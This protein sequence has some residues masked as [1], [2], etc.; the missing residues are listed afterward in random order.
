M[1]DVAQFDDSFEDL[2]EFEG[3]EFEDLGAERVGEPEPAPV[4][5]EARA[6]A[7]GWK[8]LAEFK[9]D[10]RRWTDAAAFIAHGEEELPILRDQ[11]RR[12]SERLARLDPEMESLRKTVA[13]QAAAIKYV[14]G[15]AKRADEIG[16]KR[17]LAE[18]EAQRRGAVET[19]DTV[20]FDQ[21]QAQ[22]DTL[23]QTRAAE[24][25]EPAPAPVVEGEWPETT[26]FKRDNPWVMTDPVLRQAM[27]SAHGAMLD[28]FPT[29]SRTEQYER[30]KRLVMEAHPAKFPRQPAAEPELDPEY[31][32]EPPVAREPAPPPA[33]PRARPPAR[34]AVL[35]PS[36][37]QRPGEGR[38]S[39]WDQIPEDERA[40]ARSGYQYALKGD[41]DLPASEYVAL[42]INPK[43]NPLDLRAR[44]KK[45]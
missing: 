7:M 39:V 41:P 31:E 34:A 20:A 26:A 24:P 38:R 13:E 18:L 32:D 15:L 16:Y 29:L 43:L 28:N 4:S 10:P 23:V 5:V 45:A 42:Y 17:A 21:V 33:A 30:A 14:Q 1:S 2:G 27:I 12:M 11:N 36:A 35:A 6:R 3:D 37:P 25:P 40:D 8:P 44:R 9:G 19:G 22:I